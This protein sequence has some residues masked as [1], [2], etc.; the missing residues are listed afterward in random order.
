VKRSLRHAAAA[1]LL[2]LGAVG[3]S[4]FLTGG[5]LSNDPNNPTEATNQQLFVGVQS[6][7]W[8][9]LSGD[10]ARIASTWAQ[11]FQ[12]I[13]IQYRAI[14]EYLISESTTNASQQ[15]IYLGGGLVDVRKLQANTREIGDSLF[16]G[17]AQV[18]EAILIGTE[19]DLFGDVVY[20]QALQESEFPNPALDEQLDVYAALQT[21]LD[22][23]IVNMA[24][25]ALGTAGPT[26]VGPAEADLAYGGNAV[27]WT[28]LAH[29]LKARLYMHVAEVDASA[30]QRAYDEAKL[31]ILDPADDF[32]AVFS[33]AAFEQNFW[34]QF[35][36]A[37]RP[38]DIEPDSVFADT[39]AARGDPRLTEYFE[40]DAAGNA[41]A[42]SA[43]RSAPDFGQ[44]LVTANQNLL[45]W[46]EA[47][48]RLGLDA[49]ALT[50]LNAERSLVPLPA[51]SG[52]S[53]RPLLNEILIEKWIA[54]FQSIEAYNDYKR[55]CTPNLVPTVPNR[56]IPGRLYYD[57]GERQTNTSIPNPEDQPARNDNDPANAVS[58][59]TGAPC[60][61]Q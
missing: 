39:L 26:N 28:K 47:A 15:A 48:Q 31:G 50:Q 35:L 16:L 61:G 2:L 4:D 45:V 41:I 17:V 43:E 7:L 46:A 25:S 3:C 57:T 60:L 18:Q 58:D 8:S 32:K 21:L 13:G 30:Y 40:L 22:E 51:L 54:N 44:P 33:G 27:Q 55:T 5:D 11:Q 23:A 12:G 52:L 14:D 59:G 36:I 29:T 19:A 9:V 56:L 38:G 1:G 37:Q 49:E 24:P 20:S 10:L 53:G 42:V 34:Y 6:T